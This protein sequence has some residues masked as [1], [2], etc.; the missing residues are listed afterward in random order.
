MKETKVEEADL[1]ESG[2]EVV[3][4]GICG[5]SFDSETELSRHLWTHQVTIPETSA[6]DSSKLYKCTFCLWQLPPSHFPAHASIH[7]REVFV[8]QYDLSKDVKTEDVM[9][10]VRRFLCCRCRK[11]FRSNETLRRHFEERHQGKGTLLLAID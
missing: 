8:P 9:P 3:D 6:Y 11:H 5:Q 7:F 1:K 10:E 2:E 4:C